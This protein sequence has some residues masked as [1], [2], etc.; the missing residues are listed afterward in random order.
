MFPNTSAW[1]ISNYH[2]LINKRNLPYGAR[3]LGFQEGGGGLGGK[4][5]PFCGEIWTFSGTTV[6]NVGSS[7]LEIMLVKSHTPGT[8]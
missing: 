5:N 6:H 7:G 2:K 4:K 3:N 8:Y 1:T